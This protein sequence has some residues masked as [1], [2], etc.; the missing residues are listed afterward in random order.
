LFSIFIFSDLHFV[1]RSMADP[2]F[3]WWFSMS[4]QE[5]QRPVYFSWILLLQLIPVWCPDITELDCCYSDKWRLESPSRTTAGLLDLITIF[6]S[7][8]LD[9]GLEGV[10]VFQSPF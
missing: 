4:H 2:A 8:S 9:G 3:S 7:L 5:K 10:K 6:S 1:E